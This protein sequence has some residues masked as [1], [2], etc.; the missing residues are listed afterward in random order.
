MSFVCEDESVLWDYVHIDMDYQL[1]VIR[2]I[3]G[4]QAPIAEA[5]CTLLK[6]LWHFKLRKC[7]DQRDKVFA[8]LGICKELKS[9]DVKIEYSVSVAQVYS[10]VARFI[11]TRDCSLKLLRVCQ[12]Y[13][14][15]H[16]ELLS[17]VPNWNIES[18]FRATRPI[19]SWVA[20]DQDDI[21]NASG[22]L[23]AHVEFSADLQTM[24]IQGLPVAKISALGT[25]LENNGDTIETPATQKKKFSLFQTWWPLAKA[26]TPDLNPAPNNSG[27][28]GR[29]RRFDAF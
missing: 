11:I 26:H 28:G 17:W 18:R 10:E 25:H 7:G 27:G 14:S 1:N 21:F 3:C 13:G 8:I 16:V 19:S 12:S 20:G 29:E 2:G 4:S 23:S 24:S 6:Q 9:A 5:E 15:R 22:S